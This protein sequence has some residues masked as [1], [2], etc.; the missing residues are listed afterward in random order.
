MTI[1]EDSSQ[2]LLTSYGV[3]ISV[4]GFIVTGQC[5]TS[6]FQLWVIENLATS[7]I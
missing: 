1:Q 7:L 2:P 6:E 4:Q 5:I 3:P